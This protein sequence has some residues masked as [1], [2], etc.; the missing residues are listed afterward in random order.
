MSAVGSSEVSADRSSEVSADR[1]S[2]GS[3]DGSADGLADGD[4][5]GLGDGVTGS[6]DVCDGAAAAAP[7]AY[8]TS[9]PQPHRPAA[10]DSS[11]RTGNSRFFNLRIFTPDFFG[12]F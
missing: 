12:A 3:D 11:I 6:D 1:S 2:D 4:G 5:D 7:S 9:M 8:V 10:R